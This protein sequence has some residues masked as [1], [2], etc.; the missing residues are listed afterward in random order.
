[1]IDFRLMNDQYQEVDDGPNLNE[2]YDPRLVAIYDTVNPVAESGDLRRSGAHRH[3]TRS[4]EVLVSTNELRFRTQ[5]EL[6]RS[7]S[8]AGFSVESV[9]GDWDSRP[10]DAAS[11]ELIFVAAF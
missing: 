2:F 3:F 4:G 9:F 7:L 8:D 6:N 5:A 1:M 11:R 10:A